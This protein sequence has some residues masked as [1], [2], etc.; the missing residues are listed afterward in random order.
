[1]LTDLGREAL[2][3]WAREPTPFPR[4]QSEAVVRLVAADILADDAALAASLT[5][6]RR[7]LDEIDAGLDEAEQ[8]AETIPHRTRYLLLVHRFGR[9]LVQ[10]HRDWL[11]EVER[12]LDAPDERG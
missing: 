12:E 4:V 3:A 9:T 7:D 8:I 10:A 11:D 1:M 6:L 5:A 2:R